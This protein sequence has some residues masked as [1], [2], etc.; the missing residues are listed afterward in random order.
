M[1][2]KVSTQFKNVSDIVPDLTGK[3]I[4]VTGAN[5]GIGMVSATE[6]A[7]KGARVYLPRT[8]LIF[9]II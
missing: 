6:F 2:M 9:V 1:G 4:I 7:K 8:R 5:S 3:N